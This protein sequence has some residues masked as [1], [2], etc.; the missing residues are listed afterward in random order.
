MSPSTR[1]G[2]FLKEISKLDT[3]AH[4]FCNILRKLIENYAEVVF[5]VAVQIHMESKKDQQITQQMV[6]Q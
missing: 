6:Q 4:R 2:I 1:E 3:S 5:V